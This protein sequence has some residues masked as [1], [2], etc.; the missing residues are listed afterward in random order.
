ML[1]H[2][3]TET[4]RSLHKEV[5]NNQIPKA[6]LVG[7]SPQS[8]SH[9]AKL[10]WERGCECVFATSYEEVCS[11]LRTLEYFLILCPIRLGARTLL[12]LMDLLEG[13]NVSLFYAAFVEHGC[14]WLPA[15]RRG[16]KCFGSCAVRS[17]EIISLV[18]ET[19]G[20]AQLKNTWTT[21]DHME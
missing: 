12:P 13:C 21:K 8:F 9:L 14:W 3:Q 18:D 10:L 2:T 20:R 19:I 4:A 1:I 16:Q 17:G 15:I 7:G 6:L 5:R 11:S